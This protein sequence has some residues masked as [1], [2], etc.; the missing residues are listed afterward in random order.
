M[1]DRCSTTTTTTTTTTSTRSQS[2]DFHLDARAR[3]TVR[4]C[5]ACAGCWLLAGFG[6]MAGWA[7]LGL[8]GCR[9]LAI[10]RANTCAHTD[11]FE[12][13]K[14]SGFLLPADVARRCVMRACGIVSVCV[15]CVRRV[16]AYF[17]KFY[18][19]SGAVRCA[20]GLPCSYICV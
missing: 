7:D 11:I 5:E 3:D 9:W 2:I 12:H 15:S 18:R 10:W 4:R 1:L 8:V 14:R 13:I 6:D 16:V 20:L 17:I 19:E